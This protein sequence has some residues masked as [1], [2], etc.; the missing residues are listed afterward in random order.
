MKVGGWEG[1]M[2]A[3]ECSERLL[4]ST[5]ELNGKAVADIPLPVRF[6]LHITVP[7]HII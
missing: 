1:L 3:L 7:E 6:L 4:Q 2:E 5:W